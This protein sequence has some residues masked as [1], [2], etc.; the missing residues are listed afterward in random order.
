MSDESG[1]GDFLDELDK[2]AEPK[3]D[4]D[5][6]DWAGLDAELDEGLEQ[7]DSP[8]EHWGDRLTLEPGDRFKGFVRDRVPNM[9]AD[10]HDVL[11]L[12]DLQREPLFFY[13][14]AMLWSEYEKAGAEPGWMIVIGRRLED[15]IGKHGAYP[16]YRVRARPADDGI[17][18]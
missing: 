18:L 9:A 3:P 4:A 13:G 1:E 8:P 12:E 15:A 2:I 10:R 11:L 16:F 17:P 5:D 7:D 6:D 14:S